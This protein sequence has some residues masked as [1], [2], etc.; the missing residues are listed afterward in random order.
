[1]PALRPPPAAPAGPRE[2][3]WVTTYSDPYAV[4]NLTLPVG[5]GLEILTVDENGQVNGVALVK[6]SLPYECTHEGRFF[7]HR[8]VQL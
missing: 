4:D 1:M 5:S 2:G 7:H 8:V 6:V 3:A